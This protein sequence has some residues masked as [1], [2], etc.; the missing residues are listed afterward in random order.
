M[1]SKG[2]I[3]AV[4]VFFSIIIPLEVKANSVQGSD[5]GFGTRRW[6][7]QRI[8]CVTKKNRFGI[9]YKSCK[10]QSRAC[11]KFSGYGSMP[12]Q[13]QSCGEWSDW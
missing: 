8:H 2:L 12:P 7:E 1:K 11:K 13:P 9:P 6:R 3:V 10:N 5:N 4:S